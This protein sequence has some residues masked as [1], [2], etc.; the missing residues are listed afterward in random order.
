MKQSE[1]KLGQTVREFAPVRFSRDGRQLVLV[2]GYAV[3]RWDIATGQELPVLN[4]PNGGL[5]TGQ[6]GAYVGFSEDG[7][8]ACSA[9]A[10]SIGENWKRIPLSSP[11]RSWIDYPASNPRSGDALCRAFGRSLC[12]PFRLILTGVRHTGFNLRCQ[13]HSVVK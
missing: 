5:L 13:Y 8:K 9:L 3:R 2:E 4:V 11:N 1:R 6:G 10:F 7:K 12:L